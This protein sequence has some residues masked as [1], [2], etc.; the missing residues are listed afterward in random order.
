VKKNFV[1][2]V[3]LFLFLSLFVYARNSGFLNIK[4]N[5]LFPADESYK[6]T[7][8]SSVFLPE[9]KAG[10]NLSNNIYIWGGYSFITKSGETPVLKIETESTQ[11]FIMAGVGYENGLTEKLFINIFGGASYINF[12]EE[13]MGTEVSDTA[14]GYNLGAELRYN[15]SKTIFVNTGVSYIYGKDTVEEVD[16]KLGGFIAGVGAGIRF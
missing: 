3:V 4:G 13:A 11:G 5:Y 10:F 16:V 7:Y 8:S 15:L 1:V 12:K 14:F 6:D 9:V 2:F